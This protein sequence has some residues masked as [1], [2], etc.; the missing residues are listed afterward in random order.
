MI[1]SLHPSIYV[2]SGY[3]AGYTK[4]FQVSLRKPY[5]LE[6]LSEKKGKHIESIPDISEIHISQ[7]NLLNISNQFRSIPVFSERML[8]WSEPYLSGVKIEELYYESIPFFLVY[9]PYMSISFDSE[10]EQK[11]KIQKIKESNI[12]NHIFRLRLIKPTSTFEESYDYITETFANHLEIGKQ[13]YGMGG[14]T[15]IVK[16]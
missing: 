13:R 7:R 1:M 5:E 15:L 4:P 2:L 9:A 16:D 12:N 11:S 3:K 6:F 14:F 10:K 8:V